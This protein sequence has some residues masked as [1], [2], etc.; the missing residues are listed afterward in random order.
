M[1]TA[2]AIK[3]TGEDMK[4]N[5]TTGAKDNGLHTKRLFGQ[6]AIRRLTALDLMFLSKGAL[7]KIIMNMASGE[8]AENGIVR[9]TGKQI[10]FT[11]YILPALMAVSAFLVLLAATTPVLVAAIV[12]YILFMFLARLYKKN[13]LAFLDEVNKKWKAAGEARKSQEMGKYLGFK[14][15]ENYHHRTDYIEILD[16]Y[17]PGTKQRYASLTA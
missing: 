17:I 1:N 4:T 6:D 3:Q 14:K 12:A 9:R 5:T 2:Q 10:L 15:Q 13:Y 7:E 8:E 16:Q 11:V